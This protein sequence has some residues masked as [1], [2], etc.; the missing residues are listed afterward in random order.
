MPFFDVQCGSGHTTEIFCKHSDPNPACKV[1]GEETR[2]LPSLIAKT[3]GLFGDSV[4]GTA[5]NINGVY[6]RGLGAHYHNAR[7]RD[8]IAR[9]KGLIPVSELG[10][11]RVERIYNKQVEE[12][13][14]LDADSAKLKANIDRSGGDMIKAIEQT[15][16]AKEILNSKE[17]D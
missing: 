7:E 10:E 12:M 8:A 1:C 9:S 15:W 13:K 4:R 11:D 3:P 17:G 5:S 16:S 2:R 6:D 14:K